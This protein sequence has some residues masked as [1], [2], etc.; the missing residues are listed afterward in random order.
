VVFASPSLANWDGTGCTAVC[1]SDS[2][3]R[4]WR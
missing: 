3:L 4:S 1:H 2:G